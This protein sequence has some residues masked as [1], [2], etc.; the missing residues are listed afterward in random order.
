MVF[1]LVQAVLAARPPLWT[2]WPLFLVFGLTGAANV[3]LLANIRHMFPAALGGRAM[4]AV[5]LF[6][7]G[8]AF[9]LQW[10]MGVIIGAFPAAEV[11]HYAP[12]AFTTALGF[13]AVGTGLALVWYLPLQRAKPV[14]PQASVVS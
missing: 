13:T 2:V 5:N 6:G 3:L 11:G 12:Q 10:W 14:E 7:I 9:V 1:S 8:G 4:S